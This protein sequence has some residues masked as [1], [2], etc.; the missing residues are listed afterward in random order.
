M[1]RLA[2]SQFSRLYAS[3]GSSGSGNTLT[4]GSSGIR[5]KMP[6]LQEEETHS[7]S[8]SIDVIKLFL[9]LNIT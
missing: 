9:R 1:Y 6:A 3:Y 7:H 2:S 8:G 5:G 4:V